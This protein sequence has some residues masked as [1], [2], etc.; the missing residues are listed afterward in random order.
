MADLRSDEINDS[1]EQ[2]MHGGVPA[3][4]SVRPFEVIIALSA[5]RR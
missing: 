2:S 3:G 1:N 5:T 4:G